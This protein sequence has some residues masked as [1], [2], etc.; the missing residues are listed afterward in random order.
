MTSV[1]STVLSLSG[2]QAQSEPGRQSSSHA[3]SAYQRKR[4]RLSD[5]SPAP[6]VKSSSRS[7]STNYPADVGSVASGQHPPSPVPRPR[8]RTHS[9][10]ASTRSNRH[11][12]INTIASTIEGHRDRRRTLSQVSIPV[13]AFIAPHPPS[14]GRSSTYHMRDPH[15]TVIQSTSWVPRLKSP[16]EEGSPPHAWCFFIGFIL[17]PLWWIASFLP[18]PQTRLVGGTDIEKGVTLDDPQVEHGTFIKTA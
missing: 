18:I 2:A 6:S 13:S 4:V 1:D 3:P 17:F 15:R 8:S 9:R 12:M 7:G 11:S 14:I 5:S 10:A 16:N